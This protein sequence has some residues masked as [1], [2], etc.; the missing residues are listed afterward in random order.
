MKQPEIEGADV[1]EYVE[2]E[3]PE[4]KVEHLEKVRTER[5]FDRKLDVWDVHT[6][7]E[8]YWVITNPTNLYA[9]RLFPSADYTLSFHIGLT[10]RIMAREGG[11]PEGWE[12]VSSAWR[13]WNQAAEALDHADE[14]E[15]F[16]AVGM[17][18]RES[19]VA[20]VKELA[21]PEMVPSGAEA[22]KAA[23]F[24]HWSELI[25][26]HVAPGS[27]SSNVR[28]YLKCVAK[29][30]WQLVSWL[31]HATGAVRFD[32]AMAVEATQSTFAAF[33]LA[34]MRYEQKPPDRCPRCASYR[35]RVVHVPHLEIEP[36][37]VPMC[38]SCGW[39]RE[40]KEAPGR[41]GG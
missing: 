19:L 5:V 7:A 29:R 17:R 9:Q 39:S 34:W 14:A 31:T 26:N 28:G 35:I 27:S 1:R 38:E 20:L 2:R 33:S 6:T 4:E 21:D 8:R 18:C 32:G 3:A 36:P 25:A 24:I 16:Q 15:E 12:R 37:Y 10:A 30:T 13:R 23:D 11:R 22:P 40:D 41:E